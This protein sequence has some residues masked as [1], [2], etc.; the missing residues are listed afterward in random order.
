MLQRK[1]TWNTEGE[2][3]DLK[4]ERRV[5]FNENAKRSTDIGQPTGKGQRPTAK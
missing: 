2:D 1:I 5:V 4:G 3:G